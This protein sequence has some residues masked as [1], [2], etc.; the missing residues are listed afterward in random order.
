MA[1]AANAVM[2]RE[3]KAERSR[4]GGSVPESKTA[5]RGLMTGSEKATG[6]VCYN[7]W[8]V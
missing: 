1:E 3:L 4:L 5:Y 2:M 6:T 7:P 8:K